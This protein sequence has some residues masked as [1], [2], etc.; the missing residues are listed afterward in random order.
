MNSDY[1]D[2]D[3]REIYEELRRLRGDRHLERARREQ[4]NA[5]V[6]VHKRLALGHLQA[7]NPNLFRVLLAARNLRRPEPTQSSPIEQIKALTS[8]LNPYGKLTGG[9]YRCSL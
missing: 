8:L 6:I 2:G 1:T 7:D 4:P 9:N 3:I 5:K